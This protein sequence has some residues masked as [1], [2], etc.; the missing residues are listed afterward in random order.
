M[1]RGVS[2]KMLNS[3]DILL[4]RGAAAEML[5]RESMRT[6]ALVGRPLNHAVSSPVSIMREDAQLFI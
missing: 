4:S 1:R 5:I 6:H 3:V 2:I